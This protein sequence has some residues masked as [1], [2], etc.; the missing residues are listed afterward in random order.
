MVTSL[1]ER[2]HFTRFDVW[3]LTHSMSSRLSLVELWGA[4]LYGSQVTIAPAD[5]T[6]DPHCL[7]RFLAQNGIT[8][9]NQKPSEFLRWVGMT[10][11]MPR[12][13]L[14]TLILSGE[15]LRAA[16]L[17][18]WFDVGHRWPQVIYLYGHRGPMVAG[19]YAKVTQFDVVR[20]SASGLAGVPLSCCRFYVLDRHRQPVPIGVVGEIYVA[21]DGVALGYI[22]SRRHRE[23]VPDPFGVDPDSK[24]YRTGDQG[25]WT[26]EGQIELVLPRGS[27][28]SADVEASRI[29]NELLSHP[30]VSKAS[31]VTSPNTAGSD[32]FVAYVEGSHRAP[33]PSE[34][35]TYLELNLPAYMVPKEFICQP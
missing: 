17:K 22:E 29:E 24:L 2:L 4:L 14:H 35:R 26:P 10:S 1:D 6:E 33:S 21:G 20:R 18:A 7:C 25:F 9:V 12:H 32:S 23:C 15:P 8:V 5:V 31:V 34:L 27:G 3:S 11:L 13:R 16:E 30:A 19:A 28:T